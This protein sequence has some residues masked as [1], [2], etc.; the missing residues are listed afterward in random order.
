MSFNEYVNK[1]NKIKLFT[2]LQILVILWKEKFEQMLAL[3]VSP[4]SVTKIRTFTA[5]AITQ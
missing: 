1:T 5:L 3:P 2:N 4:R